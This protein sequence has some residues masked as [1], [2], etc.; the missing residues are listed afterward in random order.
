MTGRYRRVAA[1][2]C[3][4]CCVLCSALSVTA[5]VADQEKRHVIKVG[6]IDYD[7][8]ITEEKDGTYTGYGVEYLRKIAEYTGWEYEFE[9]DSWDQQLKKLETGEIDMICQAQ[10][11]KE[12]EKQYLFSDYAIGAETSVLY[13]S[14]END[15]YYYNDYAAYNGMRVGML[16]DSF[17][18]QEFRDYAA[19]K[20]FSYEESIYCL[21]YTSPSPRD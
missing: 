21:L 2:I 3:F 12:R 8:F 16:R 1:L 10:R 5:A 17:Q 4:V 14:K 6:Y 13:V 7:G 19:E 11:T 18:N 20:G 15:I 9:Y